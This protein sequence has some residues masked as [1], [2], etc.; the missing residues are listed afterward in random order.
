MTNL[1]CPRQTKGPTYLLRMTVG[2]AIAQL[3][4]AVPVE[5]R[6]APLQ[7]DLLCLRPYSICDWHHELDCRS[8]VM[9]SSI[10]A[11]ASACDGPFGC[12]MRRS[13]RQRYQLPVPLSTELLAACSSRSSCG[14]FVGSTEASFDRPTSSL[15]GSIELVR[16]LLLVSLLGTCGGIGYDS[17]CSRRS[18]MA[19]E[20]SHNLQD[21]SSNC[22]ADRVWSSALPTFSESR[23]FFP[24]TRSRWCRHIPWSICACESC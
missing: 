23:Q 5:R 11:C 9:E 22:W 15:L 19:R 10:L 16:V 4:A 2:G 20:S 8:D 3:L 1:A 24:S 12:L 6:W 7:G 13:D 18:L 17:P 21:G 14:P